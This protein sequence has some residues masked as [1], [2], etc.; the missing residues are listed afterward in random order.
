MNRM[1]E[2]LESTVNKSSITQLKDFFNK[3]A[4]VSK[5]Y[6]CSDYCIDDSN[7]PNDIITFVIFPHIINIPELKDIINSMQKTDLKKCRTVTNEF[8]NFIKSGLFFS[9]SFKLE[10]NNIFENYTHKASLE[11]I[12]SDYKDITDNWQ[13]TTPKN[14]STYKEMSKQ[15]ASLQNSIHKKSFNYK[16]LRRTFLT[17]FLASYVKLLIY[18]E[19]PN[20][21]LFSWLSDR[22]AMTNWHNGIYEVLYHITSHNMISKYISYEKSNSCAELIPENI[23]DNMFYDEMNRVADFICGA[24][25]DYNYSNNQVTGKKQCKLIEDAISSND[26]LII[27]V[28]HESGVAKIKHTKA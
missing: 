18:R 10:K 13:I 14:T 19:V 28:I 2:L 1:F 12:I 15:L 17:T 6:V 21:E 7:K 8:C 4:D 11:K 22:D 27:I 24:L 25:A 9:I 26:F 20:I 23:N 16:L 3:Y 5:W